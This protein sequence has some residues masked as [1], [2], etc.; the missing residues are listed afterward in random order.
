MRSWG[1]IGVRARS[2]VV[3]FVLQIRSSSRVWRARA[4]PHVHRLMYPSRTRDV[5]SVLKTDYVILNSRSA[6]RPARLDQADLNVPPLPVRLRIE[7][8][9]FIRTVRSLFR[10]DS[11]SGQLSSTVRR[12][13]GAV[14]GSDA[15]LGRTAFAGASVAAATTVPWVPEMTRR[16]EKEPLRMGGC[17]RRGD[18]RS[19]A[20]KRDLPRNAVAVLVRGPHPLTEGA[21][22][23]FTRSPRQRP[24]GARS[25]R[26]CSHCSA[27]TASR[28]RCCGCSTTI[29]CLMTG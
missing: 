4:C 8:Y 25:I 19:V 20:A 5:L 28:R 10:P 27:L 24:A 14:P 21:R 12:G 22:P 26:A 3:T 23:A 6:A 7:P 15:G 2:F 11:R 16:T 17:G 9:P 18:E 13:R 29:R 1:G